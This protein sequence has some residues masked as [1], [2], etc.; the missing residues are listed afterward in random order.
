MFINLFNHLIENEFDPLRFIA[1]LW[2]EPQIDEILSRAAF[3]VPTPGYN[4]KLTF[5]EYRTELLP[6]IGWYARNPKLRTSKDYQLIMHALRSLLPPQDPPNL[7]TDID[8]P[9]DLP[10]DLP[11]S[12]ADNSVGAFSQTKKP[13]QG[14]NP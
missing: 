13:N 8:L 5:I 6:L 3:L 14:T 10:I 4:R 12:T 9:L 1:I 2:L 11:P 7:S